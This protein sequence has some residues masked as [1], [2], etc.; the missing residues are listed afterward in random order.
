MLCSL[1]I[2][3]N[4]YDELAVPTEWYLQFTATFLSEG[5]SKMCLIRRYT[6]FTIHIA[7]H[8]PK[9]SKQLEKLPLHYHFCAQ[10]KLCVISGFLRNV[11]EIC[12]LLGYYAA[13]SGSSVPTFRYN[14]TVPYSRVRW[15]RWVVPK[16]RY[17]TTT[18]RC[19]I[20]QKSAD[21]K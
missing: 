1:A 8:R 11:D 13:L 19:I 3:P 17:R 6:R 20:T 2:R 4:I 15:N 21:R 18:Q 14:L 7:W 12:A 16:R 5:A 10:H 9:G